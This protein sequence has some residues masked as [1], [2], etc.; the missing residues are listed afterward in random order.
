MTTPTGPTPGSRDDDVRAR[1]H[2]EAA[3]Y[4]E[5]RVYSMNNPYLPR[6]QKA[7]V[8]AWYQFPIGVF[9]YLLMGY[10]AIKDPYQYLSAFLIAYGVAA[11]VSLLNWF[12]SLPAPVLVALG[13]LFAG[14]IETAVSLAFALFFLYQGGWIASGL[15]VASACGVLSIISPPVHLY[16]VLSGRGMHFKY[17]FAKRRFGISFP[18]EGK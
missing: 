3:R 15:S 6:F 2:R 8:E 10:L 1:I 4:A 12:V 18:F 14:W 5:S 16:A 11:V 7:L 13:L 17:R 9:G